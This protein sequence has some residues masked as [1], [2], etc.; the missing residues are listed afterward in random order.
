MASQP[1]L[2]DPDVLRRYDLPGPGYATYPSIAQFKDSFDE[3]DLREMVA[4]SNGDPIPRPLSLYLHIP[5][6]THACFYCSCHRVIT[7]DT[8]RGSSYLT[9]LYRE[10]GLI[11][12]LFDR[13]RDVEQV[14]FGGGTPNFLSSAQIAEAMD[15][16]RRH[17]SFAAPSRLDSCIKLDPRFIAPHAIG[18]LALA[19]FNRARLGVQDFHPDVQRAINRQ[20]SAEQTLTM[21][22]ACRQHGFRSVEVD[23]I[24]GLPQQHLASF[25]NTLNT[26]LQARPDRLAINDFK[27]LASS[28]RVQQHVDT[29]SLPT[30]AL[31]LDMLRCAIDRL[32]EAGY[33]HLGMQR[34]ALPGDSWVLAQQRG[35]LLRDLM[36]F[37]AHGESDLIGLGVSAISH[38]G[39]SLSQNP[40]DLDRWEQA[41]DQGHLPVWRG[42]RLAEDDVIRADVIQQLMCHGKLD[43]EALSRR[44]V[45]EFTKY[46]AHALCCLHPLHK[47]GL[48]Q[49]SN[50]GLQTT[51]HGRLL[52]RII[53]MCFDRYL[54][55]AS[56]LMPCDSRAV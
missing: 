7:Q 1:L 13:D 3:A 44:H 56:A 11:S 8:T 50:D 37:T 30:V 28:L 42:V 52:L 2:F 51:S 18:E 20:Q 9:R 12:A 24:Y 22:D 14:H 49:L 5:F 29:Q 27:P 35:E 15:V 43:Y 32:G 40:C 36:G 53:A 39:Q 4:A 48:V 54:P 10:A 33:V 21:M 17:F 19:G 34:F 23:L 38:I 46:F 47:D 55:T 6:C 45:I 25:S 26:I 16:L 41:I 31:K